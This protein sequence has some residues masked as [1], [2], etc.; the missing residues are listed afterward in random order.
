MLRFYKHPKSLI[1]SAYFLT[2]GYIKITLPKNKSSNSFI[3]ITT[4]FNRKHLKPEFDVRIL[5][6]SQ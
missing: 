3:K 5:G 1:Y 6:K 4:F 2:Y